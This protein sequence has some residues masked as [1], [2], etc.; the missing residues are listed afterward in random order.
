MYSES[1]THNGRDEKTGKFRV[2]YDADDLV[3]ALLHLGG[4]GSTKEVA[5]EVACS[6]RTTHY[7][8]EDLLDAKRVTIRE[9]GRSKSWKV[10][11]NE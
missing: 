4:S 5:D 6:C 8:L 7:R 3:K 9:V 11:S 1:S 10:V 2:Q